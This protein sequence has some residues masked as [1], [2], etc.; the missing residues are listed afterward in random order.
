MRAGCDDLLEEGQ[1]FAG[2]AA[3]LKGQGEFIFGVYGCGVKLECVTKDCGG[4]RVSIRGSEGATKL[5]CVFDVVCG[6]GVRL[7]E[8]GYGVGGIME[9]EEDGAKMIVRGGEIRI[10]RDGLTELRRCIVVVFLLGE[11]G[12]ERV[13][14]GRAVGLSAES[15]FELALRS[16]GLRCGDE[17]G[18][19][20]DSRVGCE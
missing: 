14:Q 6:E 1:R 8:L 16:G 20:G 15:F 3:G 10:E 9:G 11:D 7:G 13:V 5:Q 4:L 19:V 18:G 2:V 12:A 17:C